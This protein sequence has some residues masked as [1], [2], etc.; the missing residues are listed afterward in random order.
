MNT[1]YL[2]V[3]LS[4]MMF[5]G[6]LICLEVGRAVGRRQLGHHSG[7]G[8]A[9]FS[10]VDGALFALLGLVLA[11]TFSGAGSRFEARRDLIRQ[12]AN[13]ISTAYLRLDLLPE[14]RQPE[15]RGAFR[16]Y[17]AARLAYYKDFGD[18]VVSARRAARVAALQQEIWSKS[19]KAASEVQGPQAT[20][21][22]LPAL[23]DMIDI[24]TTRKVATLNHP[25]VVIYYMLGVLALAASVLAGFGMASARERSLL[26]T[27]GFA[28]AL[29]FAFYITLELEY[30]RQGL[31]RIDKADQIL[32]DVGASM[33][34][35]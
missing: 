34:P 21:V 1:D 4:V 29:T 5:V 22:L 12:E 9:G 14:G 20:T 8:S 33:G 7:E 23:N 16:Q 28:I 2:P 6:V 27:F 11:F 32:A 13:A 30:P 25:P 24:T 26:H 19:V 35:R 3:I 10:A 18:P 17:L 15:L 31:I